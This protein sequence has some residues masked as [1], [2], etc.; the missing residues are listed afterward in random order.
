MAACLKLTGSAQLYFQF[1]PW[2]L[3]AD[4]L[5]R[6]MVFVAL[7]QAYGKEDSQVSLSRKGND[8]YDCQPIKSS[9]KL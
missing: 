8:G 2:T 7:A 5:H 4:V 6:G 3:G 9:G 1:L